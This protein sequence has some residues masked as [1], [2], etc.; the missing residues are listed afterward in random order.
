M[1]YEQKIHKISDPRAITHLLSTMKRLTS[2]SLACTIALSPLA[3][4]PVVAQGGTQSPVIV[5]DVSAQP[6]GSALADLAR[7]AGVTITADPSLVAGKTAV[8]VRGR[9]T[10]RDA[11]GRLLAGSG[12][13][14]VTREGEIVLRARTADITSA[15]GRLDKVAIIA[16]PSSKNVV[17]EE[18]KV[19]VLGTLSVAETPFSIN[20]VSRAIIDA[21]QA[22]YL[23]DYVKNDPSAVVSN[24]P[25][26]F[27]TLRGFGLGLDGTLYDGLLGYSGLTDGRGQLEAIDR[28]DV[29]KGPSSVLYGVGASSSLGG[30]FNYIPK[31]PPSSP[32]RRL[33]VNYAGASLFGVNADFGDRFGPNDRFGYRLNLGYKDG[34]QSTSR[35]DW[36][37]R[38]LAAAVDWRVTSKLFLS[39][40]HEVAFN[41]MP[42]LQPFFVLAPG[43]P[44]PRAPNASQNVAQP[45]DD[46]QTHATN[47]YL[48]A[49]WALGGSWSFTMKGLRNVHDRPAVI[50]ARF[51]SINNAAGDVTLFGDQYAYGIT[52]Y[53]GVSTLQGRAK[54]GVIEHQISVG[55]N[56]TRDKSLG[57]ISD[58]PLGFFDTNLYRPVESPNPG[59]VKL[60]I[61]ENQRSHIAGVFASDIV[62]MSEKWSALV[63]LRH[64]KIEVLNYDIAT[65]QKSPQD[66]SL[67]ATSPTTALMFTPKKGVLLYANYAEGIEQGGVAPQ[68]SANV[69]QRLSPIRTKQFEVG[70]KYAVGPS[71]LT[72]AVFNLSRPQE[73]VDPTTKIFAQ[74]GRQ[75]HR[76]LE[77][78]IT[79]DVMRDLTLVAGTM[80]LDPKSLRTGDATT[81]GKRPI[82][83]P[84]STA[85]LWASY[86]VPAL[87]GF[88][89]NGGVYYG[90]SQ[91]LD[92]TNTQNIDAF[93]RA[94]I[95]AQYDVSVRG[96]R[97]S[98]LFSLEN[99]ADRDYW[100]S[101]QSGI[102][103]LSNPRTLKL[104]TRVDF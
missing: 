89:L 44:V 62:K 58:R 101:A 41:D 34:E 17:V 82:G 88:S 57:S 42:R 40:H 6:L 25:V 2:L 30:T 49:D 67:S 74:R 61:G 14:A 16:A 38:V 13:E 64:S 26:G 37:H 48:R 59:E 22:A 24:V 5:L 15:V 73:Y 36:N 31:A 45:W 94:D 92:A 50:N 53:S 63:G 93:T 83:V 56:I 47:T 80:L 3:P 12:L 4:R 9:L 46:F 29:L 97:M 8:A 11:L 78:T 23:G 79:G 103:V 55:A 90:S 104:T 102:L 39:T 27:I 65:G 91:Y 60:T 10:L 19:G 76:G 66:N 87:R 28:I 32:I 43:V 70:G 69:N 86:R 98:Y 81:E 52:T 100:S 21:Q 51:G 75:R 35:Y 1:I 85:N 33:E 71:T 20:V 99:V 95:G 7:Q 68:G 18:A 54:S 84:T 77:L 72:A 96:M